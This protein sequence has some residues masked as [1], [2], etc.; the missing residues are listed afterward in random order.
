MRDGP[1][2]RLALGAASLLVLLFLVAPLLVMSAA[3]I[4]AARLLAPGFRAAGVEL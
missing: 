4:G 1:V 3:V 2:V